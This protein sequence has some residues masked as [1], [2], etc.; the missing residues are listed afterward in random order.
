MVKLASL[1]IQRMVC[2]VS[3]G[4]R[5]P[6]SL[7]WLSMLSPDRSEANGRQWP[8]CQTLRAPPYVRLTI[9]AGRAVSIRCRVRT[10]RRRRMSLL[11]DPIVK[12]GPSS[13]LRRSTVTSPRLFIGGL[14]D[15]R[16]VHNVSTVTRPLRIRKCPAKRISSWSCGTTSTLWSGSSAD[17]QRIRVWSYRRRDE[18]AHQLLNDP[19]D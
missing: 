3:W 8:D 2:L 7:C 10:A 15:G 14:S 5:P 9:Q 4:T 12:V 16:Q 6:I 11:T 19:S 13:A 18:I 17:D 1:P